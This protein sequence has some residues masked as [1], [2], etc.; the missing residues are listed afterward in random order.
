MT[1][2]DQIGRRGQGANDEK[3]QQGGEHQREQIPERGAVPSLIRELG[4]QPAEESPD[5]SESKSNEEESH[6]APP[7]ERASSAPTQSYFIVVRE[8]VLSNDGHHGRL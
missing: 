2:G 8:N 3:S 7:G 5:D 1:G 4:D 6:G